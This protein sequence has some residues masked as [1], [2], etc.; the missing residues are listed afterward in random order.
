MSDHQAKDLRHDIKKYK[1]ELNL[2][3]LPKVFIASK[4]YQGFRE[5]LIQKG[6]VENPDFMSPIFVLK[7]CVRLKHIDYCNLLP[8]QVISHYLGAN[9]LTNKYELSKNIKNLVSFDWVDVDEFFPRCYDL[10]CFFDHSNFIVD[11]QIC[12]AV[13]VIKKFAMKF[14]GF[15]N[16]KSSKVIGKEIR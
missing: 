14:V 5:E 15:G 13:V 2:E 11:F 12:Q 4:V 8:E 16:Q 1:K 9:S 6:W 10:N 3:R 7:Y